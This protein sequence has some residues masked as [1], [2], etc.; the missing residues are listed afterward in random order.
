[1]VVLFGVPDP[2]RPALDGGPGME[3]YVTRA[4]NQ[5]RVHS[6]FHL[7]SFEDPSLLTSCKPRSRF[8]CLGHLVRESG[9]AFHSLSGTEGQISAAREAEVGQL[10]SVPS[11]RRQVQK[12]V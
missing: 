9:M 1:M 3:V 11:G 7:D 2:Q 5:R 6:S 8:P 4:E 10:A 12:S